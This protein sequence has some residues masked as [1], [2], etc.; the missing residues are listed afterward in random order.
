MQ[1]IGCEKCTIYTSDRGLMSRIYKV[2][3][4]N[5]NKKTTQFLNG[6]KF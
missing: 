2:L 3:L 4:Q 1:A 6:Q 5:K